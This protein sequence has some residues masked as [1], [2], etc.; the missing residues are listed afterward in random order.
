M[1]LINRSVWFSS[2][3]KLNDPFDCQ[4]VLED[5]APTKD[6]FEKRKKSALQRY[7]DRVGEKIIAITPSKNCYSGNM[8]TEEYKAEIGLFKAHVEK[9]L[10]EVGVFS[11]SE[12]NTN[13]TM[14]SHYA[15]S[16][17]GICVGY[18]THKL[19]PK[20]NLDDLIHQVR[21]KNS[22]EIRF[23]VYDIYADCCCNKDEKTYFDIV[24]TLM[25]T[26]LKDWSYEK[27][28]RFIHDQE[29]GIH[30]GSDSI[31]SI[32]FGMRTKPEEKATIRN[33]LA[34]I[35]VLFF[36]MKPSEAGLRLEAVNMNKKSKYWVRYPGNI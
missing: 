20:N 27:E 11:V 23:N 26:K 16:H 22:E 14:W 17:S 18:F 19:F 24:N 31:H 8:L 7:A 30:V 5:Y 15:S 21:Y 25:S 32:H 28:W 3:A 13:T 4:L 2:P 33:I 12:E 9:N 6:V 1:E 29:G 35:P 36:Q 34:N 10:R